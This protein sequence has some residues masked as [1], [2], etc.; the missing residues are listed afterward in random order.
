MYGV[1]RGLPS[2]AADEVGT[3]PVPL[4]V[5]VAPGVP[6]TRESGAIAAGAGAG[7]LTWNVAGREAW[8]STLVTVTATSWAAVS[9]LAGTAARSSLVDTNE[10]EIAA[11]PRPEGRRSTP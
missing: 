6:E 8:P 1:P 2:Q 7:F 10:V 11:A 3:K 5:T 9:S 4:I